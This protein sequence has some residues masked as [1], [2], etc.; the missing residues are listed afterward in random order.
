VVRHTAVIQR[1]N[2]EAPVDH[3]MGKSS[4]SAVWYLMPPSEKV[5][6]A[7]ADVMIDGLVCHASRSIAEICRPAAQQSVH[8]VAHFRPWLHVAGHQYLVDLPFHTLDTF[9]AWTCA[10]VPVAGCR[11][12]GSSGGRTCIRG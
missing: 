10:Q 12:S 3:V 7:S 1:Q 5:S 2:S 9:L 6:D 4:C 11:S 8:L